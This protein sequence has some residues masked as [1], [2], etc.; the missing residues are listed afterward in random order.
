[1]FIAMNRFKITKGFEAGFE[2]VWRQRDSYLHTVEG[3]KSFSL[4][5]GGEFD[6][7]TLYASHTIW[8]SK[9]AFE[10]WTESEAFRK[11]HGQAKA[12]K[13]TYLGP[14]NL[15]LFEGVNL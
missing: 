6:D 12:P 10:A 8:E 5:K 9:Q 11:A 15:E 3:F 1:M 13:G 2:E 4:L 7:H 14:P